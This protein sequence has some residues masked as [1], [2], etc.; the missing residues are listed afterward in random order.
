MNILVTG[1]YGFIGWHFLNL[2]KQ[3]PNVKDIVNVDKLTYAACNAPKHVLSPSVV[4][5]IEPYGTFYK[6]DINDCDDM[7]WIVK[8]HKIDVIVN[9]AA[10]SHVDNSINN[11]A[12]FVH[13]NIVGTSCLLNVAREFAC[14]FVQVST[15]E[16]YGH[17]NADSEPFNEN[18]PYNPRNPYSATK[19]AADHLVMAYGNTHGMHVA[20]TH[21]SNNYGPGQHNEKLIPKTICNAINNK[22]IPVYGDGLQVR[23][24]IFVEDH[25]R[26]VLQIATDVHRGNGHYCIGAS[27]EITNLHLVNSICERLDIVRPRPQGS[28]KDLVVHVQD[29]PGHDRRYAI[30]SAKMQKDYGWMPE[31]SFEQGIN[32]TID[33]YLNKL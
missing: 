8:E 12:P 29:R 33:Y 15:D 32:K 11:N 30:N 31:T 20:V 13:T 26:A 1:G 19:A 14:R 2:A 9:F 23:D 25:A 24:W 28:Y 18:T 27:N 10:E 17:L 3:H 16:V 21:C 5:S 6:N 22:L 4:H 7:K